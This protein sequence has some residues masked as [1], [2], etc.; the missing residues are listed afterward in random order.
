MGGSEMYARGL[1]AALAKP[2]W[3][4]V[5][6][7]DVSMRVRNTCSKKSQRAASTSARTA[8][9]GPS[10]RRNSGVSGL[11]PINATSGPIVSK[12]PEQ[13]H[14]LRYKLRKVEVQ[15]VVQRHDARLGS[16]R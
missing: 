5:P 10:G 15:E 3:V 16:R 7:A 1:V 13:P 11:H 12:P 2:K 9:T 8:A 4:D 6:F 14:V